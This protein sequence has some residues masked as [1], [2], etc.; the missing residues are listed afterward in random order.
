MLG[1]Y[2]VQNSGGEHMKYD[3]ILGF[4]KAIIQYLNNLS[5]PQVLNMLKQ[6][7]TDWFTEDLLFKCLHKRTEDFNILQHWSIMASM[8][9]TVADLF[10]YEQLL[11]LSKLVM[12]MKNIIFNMKPIEIIKNSK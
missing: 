7:E 6:A 3:A 1:N 11:Y 10:A 4:S 9:S 8:E 2:T 12:L 5:L